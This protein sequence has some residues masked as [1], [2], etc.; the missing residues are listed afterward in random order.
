MT[1]GCTSSRGRSEL[2]KYQNADGAPGTHISE[3]KETDV[4]LYVLELL[5]A[6]TKAVTGE[7]LM[8]EVRKK[9]R[10]K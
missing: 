6:Q 7:V 8:E 3:E 2:S 10:T 5:D 1:V 4:L 9:V